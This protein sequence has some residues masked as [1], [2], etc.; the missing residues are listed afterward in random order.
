VSNTLALS[1][2]QQHAFMTAIKPLGALL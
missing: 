1:Q 2:K